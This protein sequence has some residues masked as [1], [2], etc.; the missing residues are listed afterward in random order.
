MKLRSQ[1]QPSPE[2]QRVAA[3]VHDATNE[4]LHTHAIN[5]FIICRDRLDSVREALRLHDVIS[6][7]RCREEVN[8]DV[9]VVQMA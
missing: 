9:I 1:V 2:G 4:T 8:V 5:W 6:D 7:A 3:V